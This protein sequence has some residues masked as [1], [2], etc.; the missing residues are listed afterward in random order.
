MRKV[1]RR[2]AYS[3]LLLHITSHGHTQ[4]PFSHPLHLALF[5]CE[6][7]YLV[8]QFQL[9]PSFFFQIPHFTFIHVNITHCYWLMTICVSII[10]KKNFFFLS[11][12]INAWDTSKSLVSGPVLIIVVA[13]GSTSRLQHQETRVSSKVCS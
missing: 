5:T 13:V 6:T 3:S 8:E 1:C 2:H 10:I 7:T 4:M 12:L 11:W 9:L